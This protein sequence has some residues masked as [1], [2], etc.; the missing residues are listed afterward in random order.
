MS[1]SCSSA[2]IERQH[3]SIFFRVVELR[4]S[5]GGCDVGF[6]PQITQV[7]LSNASM[8][9]RSIFDVLRYDGE[10]AP[11]AMAAGR[12]YQQVGLE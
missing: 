8:E 2:L 1:S 5:A 10:T 4:S 3:R 9:S 11:V 7:G 12:Q 6:V